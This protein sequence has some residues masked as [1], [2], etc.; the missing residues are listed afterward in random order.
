MKKKR[1]ENKKRGFLVSFISGEIITTRWH[2]EWHQKKKKQKKKNGIH[3][4]HIVMPSVTNTAWINMCFGFPSLLRSSSLFMYRCTN[5]NTTVTLW[6]VCTITVALPCPASEAFFVYTKKLYH[7]HSRAFHILSPR[8][9]SENDSLM[10]RSNI[11]THSRNFSFHLSKWHE[12]P[13]LQIE[14]LKD[15]RV[16]TCPSFR[17]LPKLP[18]TYRTISMV[19]NTLIFAN[20]FKVKWIRIYRIVELIQLSNFFFWESDLCHFRDKRLVYQFQRLKLHFVSRNY[21][22]IKY[23][24]KMRYYFRNLVDFLD[25]NIIL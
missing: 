12:S 1:K 19:S 20:C 6:K 18:S 10:L 9:T 17:H 21:I 15:I 23:W 2:S 11:R 8:K 5:A 25:L 22:N 7:S 14:V 13:C 3:R 16:W 24:R 4:Q